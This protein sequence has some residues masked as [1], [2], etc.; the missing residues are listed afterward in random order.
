MLLFHLDLISVGCMY[1][2][3]RYVSAVCGCRDL[4]CELYFLSAVYSHAGPRGYPFCLYFV[5]CYTK[6]VK[7][8]KIYK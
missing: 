1:S 4:R 2:I 7:E 5:P 6:A 8:T 3:R